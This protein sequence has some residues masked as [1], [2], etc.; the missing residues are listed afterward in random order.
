VHA[1]EVHADEQASARRQRGRFF[2][3][4]A[5]SQA[6]NAEGHPGQNASGHWGLLTIWSAGE[7]Q[8]EAALGQTYRQ[9][10]HLSLGP[11]L[12]LSARARMDENEL[13]AFETEIAHVFLRATLSVP[14]AASSFLRR[15][16]RK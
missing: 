7:E 4:Q 5:A 2:Q 16:V 12:K 3:R 13:A 9:F 10:G 8:R 15:Y 6:G 14:T 11:A 1:C